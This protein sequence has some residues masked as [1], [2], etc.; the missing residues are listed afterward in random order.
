MTDFGHTMRKTL[1]LFLTLG[2]YK[3]FRP[4]LYLNFKKLDLQCLTDFRAVSWCD[5]A[6][7]DS[8]PPY[9]AIVQHFSDEL[10]ALLSAHMAVHFTAQDIFETICTQACVGCGEFG[11][12]L[13]M[14]T[15]HR[16]C[17]PCVAY[18]DNSLSMT[19]DVIEHPG[20]IL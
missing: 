5:H 11:P 15:A 4:K 2:F 10:R 12:L 18:S 20:A 19:S 8:I 14:F 17:N 6:L 13:D 1:L 16:Y 7:V 9:N 3:P